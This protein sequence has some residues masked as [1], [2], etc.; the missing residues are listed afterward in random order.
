M[1][2]LPALTALALATPTPLLAETSTEIKAKGTASTFCNISSDGGPITMTL[3]STGDKLSGEGSYSLIANGNAK[4]SLSA[5][6]Q[7]SPAGAEASTPSI[8]LADLVSNNSSSATAASNNSGGAI[9][10]QGAITTAITENN[11]TNLLSAGDY[12]LQA[13]ATC[14][15]L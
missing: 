12:A 11:S 13:T 2:I 8:S 10:K 1:K 14:T 7:T 5:V 6:S 3:S 4:V 15:S 9:R